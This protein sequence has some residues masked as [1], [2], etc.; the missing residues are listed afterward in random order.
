MGKT[1]AELTPEEIEKYVRT[2]RARMQARRRRMAARRE[3][4]WAVARR[5]AALLKDEFGVKRVMVF[6]S[7]CHPNLFYERSDVDLA[8]WGIDER[9]YLRAVGCLLNLDPEISIDLIE[10]ESARPTLRKAIEREGVEL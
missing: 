10:F 2:A 6:G 3:R 1:A 7:L 5:G 8:V 4:A 9:K